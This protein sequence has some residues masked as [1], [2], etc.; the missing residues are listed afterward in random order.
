VIRI[1]CQPDDLV[2]TNSRYKMRSVKF[3]AQ[4]LVPQLDEHERDVEFERSTAHQT[5]AAFDRKWK[6][7]HDPF[8]EQY[9]MWLYVNQFKNINRSRG[10][11]AAYSND[12]PATASS[13]LTREILFQHWLVANPGLGEVE[14]ERE[15]IVPQLVGSMRH[16]REWRERNGFFHFQGKVWKGIY[17]RTF[18]DQ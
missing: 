8:T 15:N 11:F 4:V 16:L 1:F 6:L 17:K 2:V 12:I 9:V 14:F 7:K 18:L 3:F 13:V 10:A 5:R